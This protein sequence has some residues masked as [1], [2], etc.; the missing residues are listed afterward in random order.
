MKRILITLG[1]L[2]SLSFSLSVQAEST[3][4]KICHSDSKTKKEVCKKVKVHKKVSGDKVPT[5]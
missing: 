1:I 3:V 2:L 5:K 4:E